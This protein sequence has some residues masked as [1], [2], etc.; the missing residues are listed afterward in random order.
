MSLRPCRVCGQ[1]DP[2]CMIALMTYW[3]GRYA[4]LP[5][6]SGYF[7]LCPRCHERLID[8]HLAD[9][10]HKLASE[11]PAVHKLELRP[12][13]ITRGPHE[14]AIARREP[15]AGAD[16]GAPSGPPADAP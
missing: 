11:H 12:T 9:I 8:P 5:I 2:R 3:F 14:P 4:D 16:G 15:P 7:Y 6:E 1:T 13:L 10:R